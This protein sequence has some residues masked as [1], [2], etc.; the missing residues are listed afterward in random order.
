MLKTLNS[1]LLYGTV[2]NRSVTNAELTYFSDLSDDLFCLEVF[3]TD[4]A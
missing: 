3:Q 1:E 4:S 2:L